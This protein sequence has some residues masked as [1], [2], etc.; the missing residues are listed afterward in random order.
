MAKDII[1]Y[2]QKSIKDVDVMNLIIK[3]L[4]ELETEK[5]IKV[6]LAV[7]SGSR[8]WGIESR[9]SDYDIRFVFVRKKKDYLTLDKKPEVIETMKE[10]RDYVGFDLFKFLQHIRA[11]NPSAIEWVKSGIVYKNQLKNF[12]E[13]NREI[14]ENFNPIALF[15]HYKSLT[16]NN[17]LKY[18]KEG[19]D[20]RYKRY[21]YCLRGML[22]AEF[23]LNIR[24]VP[25]IKFEDLLDSSL[26]MVPLHF[27]KKVKEIINIKKLGFEKDN[28]EKIQVLDKE[29]E[30][31]LKSNEEPDAKKIHAV[32]FLN[33]VLK[34]N[35]ED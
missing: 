30:I 1:Q 4:K 15:H 28:V 6:L 33:E 12:R 10:N 25:P 19:S 7:E 11:S 5:Q 17:Y 24:K 35:L 26:V 31:F 29:I 34:A 13:L 2:A 22:N 23:V 27:M 14:D 16:K 18:I 9:D 32:G 3:E 21:L 20:V 8:A